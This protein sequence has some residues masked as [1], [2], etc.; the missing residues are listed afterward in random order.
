MT[1]YDKTRKT[2]LTWTTGSYFYITLSGSREMWSLCVY[3]VGFNRL[4]NIWA[5]LPLFLC[6]E[7]NFKIAFLFLE[8]STD[9]WSV[10]TNLVFCSAYFKELEDPLSFRVSQQRAGGQEGILSFSCWSLTGLP[11]I[12]TET[13][14]LLIWSET[15]QSSTN[16]QISIKHSPMTHDIKSEGSVKYLSR[17]WFWECSSFPG[18]L[19][20]SGL[21]DNDKQA[22]HGFK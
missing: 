13:S 21:I 17:L 5:S 1:W 18:I 7:C 20:K 14:E 15:T 22:S 16:T 8:C 2:S 12:P 11:S 19:N 6:R 9:S 4:R 10:F 3:H